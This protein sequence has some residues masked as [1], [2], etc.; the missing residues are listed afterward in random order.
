MCFLEKEGI[1]Q[2]KDYSKERGYIL[3]DGLFL[4]GREEDGHL[5]LILFICV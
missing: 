2:R 4:F 1:F 3:E 5:I